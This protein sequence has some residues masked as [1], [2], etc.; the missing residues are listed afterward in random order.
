MMRWS[1]QSCLRLRLLVIAIAAGMMFFGVTQLRSMP[2]D[3]YPELDPPLVEVQTEVLGLSAPE[4]EASITVPMEADLLNGV[5]SL[6]PSTPGTAGWI[7]TP[8]Q[9][10]RHAEIAF[11][12][13]PDV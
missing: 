4:M 7:D 3:V 8:H 6:D 10:N 9:R 1:G 11:A 5:A 2:V 12:K 13:C